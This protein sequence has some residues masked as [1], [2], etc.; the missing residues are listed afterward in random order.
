MAQYEVSNPPLKANTTFFFIIL[1]AVFFK[2]S[3]YFLLNPRI[4]P[5]KKET[6]DRAL[7]FVA[8]A[9]LLAPAFQHHK[10]FEPHKAFEEL[11]IL[12]KLTPSGVWDWISGRGNGEFCLGFFLRSL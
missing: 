12:G 11:E 1:P 7:F 3:G 2:K 6:Q 10:L 9:F 8:L 5:K 4:L